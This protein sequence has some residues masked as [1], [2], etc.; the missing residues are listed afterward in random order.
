M[1]VYV[2]THRVCATVQTRVQSEETVHGCTAEE[3]TYI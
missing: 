3:N 2:R 1:H